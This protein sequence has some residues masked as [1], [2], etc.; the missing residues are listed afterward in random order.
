MRLK[1]IL[2]VVAMAWTS[3]AN[4]ES[5][6]KQD[7]AACRR[8]VRRFCSHVGGGDNQK[9]KACLQAHI[10]ELSQ[11]CQQVLMKHQGQQ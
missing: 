9:Y 4:A 1:N 10:Q 6:S 11:K 2:V 7:E 3:A 5:V 8:D